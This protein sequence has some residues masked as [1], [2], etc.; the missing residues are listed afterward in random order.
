MRN[1]RK[2]ILV[3]SAGRRVELVRSFLA[4]RDELLPDSQ[5]FATDLNPNLSSACQIADQHF[6]SPRASEQ[7]FANFIEEMGAS[8]H[9][10]LVIPTIDTELLPLAQIKAKLAKQGTHISISDVDFVENCRDKMKSGSVFEQIGVRY[11]KLM[12]WNAANFPAFAKPASGSSSKGAMLLRDGSLL[13]ELRASPE[14]YMLMEYIGAP[15]R[16][17]TVDA[18]FDLSSQLKCLVPRLRLEIRAGEVSKGVTR[19]HGLYEKL[20]VGLQNWRN[21]YGCITIQV[22]YD[23]ANND[24]VGLEVNPRFGGGYPLTH[25]AG[26]TFSHWLVAEALMGNPI[27]MFE[28]WDRDLLMLRYDAAIWIR[29]AGP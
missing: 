13:G 25:Q 2:N 20:K 7:S 6:V 22:F 26:A 15:Y 4:A 19:R 29:E 16:E 14:N 27:E 28:A 24:V 10:G 3:L 12:D 5:V 21:V 8:H 9:I 17:Y 1:D 18:Y 23:E 11:P